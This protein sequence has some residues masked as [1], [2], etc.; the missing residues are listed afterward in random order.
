MGL[1]LHE[2]DGETTTKVKKGWISYWEPHEGSEL[3]T[4][5][6]SPADSMTG[7]EYYVTPLTDQS[8]LYAHLTT[9]DKKVTY[10]AGF[11]WKE[12]GQYATKKEWEHYLDDF[13]LKINKP[14]M[15]Q[16]DK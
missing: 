12:S 6:I 5:V 9:N 15:V 13:A 2:N 14:L 1:T 8:N 10:Y 16:I 4:A 7:F 11:S 3:G